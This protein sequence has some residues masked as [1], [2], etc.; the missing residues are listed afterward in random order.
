MHR[1]L[2]ACIL[3]IAITCS[4]GGSGQLDVRYEPTSYEI[5]DLML[6]LAEV[7]GDDFVFDLG[8]GDGRI[9]IAAA[10]KRGARGV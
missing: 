7:T 6:D 2:I 4:P 5:V 3:I 8:C 1:K 9:V 10:A